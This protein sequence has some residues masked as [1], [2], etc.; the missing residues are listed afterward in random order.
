MVRCQAWWRPCPSLFEVVFLSEMNG[1]SPLLSTCS[2]ARVCLEDCESIKR[3]NRGQYL[4]RLLKSSH[5][6]V[7]RKNGDNGFLDK[8]DEELQLL[9]ALLPISFCE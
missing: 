5:I 2:E 3:K 7:R 8:I 6:P 4:S 9:H 1:I